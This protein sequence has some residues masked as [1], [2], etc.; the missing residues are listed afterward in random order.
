MNRSQNRYNPSRTRARRDAIVA[1]VASYAGEHGYGP[2]IRD[3]M[4]ATGISSTSVARYHLAWLA[5]NGE[6]DWTP[7]MSRGGRP[8][9]GVVVAPGAAVEV[10]TGD[11]R[12][13][14]GAFVG[15]AA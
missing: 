3:V 12:T 11:G 8:R 2:T 10:V 1:Y 13:V 14:T 5:R 15:V 4:E 7:R 6:I 9:G